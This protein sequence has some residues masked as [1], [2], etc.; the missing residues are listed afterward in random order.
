MDMQLNDSSFMEFEESTK[1]IEECINV[2]FADPKLRYFFEVSVPAANAR[3]ET[4]GHILL[5]CPDVETK[6]CFI[7]LLQSLKS[8]S[9][10][11]TTT[12]LPE[13]RSSEIGAI[14]ASLC[15]DDILLI[16]NEKI[17][18]EQ[19]C[20]EIIKSAMANYCFDIIIGKGTSARSIRLDIPRFTV[21]A[22]VEK[23]SKSLLSLLHQF[24]YVIKINDENLPKICKAKIKAECP[25]QITDDS[26]EYI[27]Y[28][29]K[30]DVRTSISYLKRV[31]EYLEFKQIE[32]IITRELVEE[33]FDIVDIGVA[34]DEVV[35]D[36]EIFAIFKEIRN[37][38]R[39][40][41]EDMHA[42]RGSI[43]DFIAANDG[44]W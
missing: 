37:S 15:S 41:Q 24:E 20:V 14:F 18:I 28:K 30:Y 40:I 31:L 44:E 35:D 32:T 4:M 9:N 13:L 23:M 19:E 29:A 11:R 25:R 38:L 16:E 43:E 36:D 5:V 1:T 39:D 27:S 22:C 17:T 3:K 26:C 8:N 7:T 42:V 21:V 6:K 12:L 33:I 2:L 34:F 10:V